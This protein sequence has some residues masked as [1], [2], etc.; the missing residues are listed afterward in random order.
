[1]NKYL[2]FFFGPMRILY[3][4]YYRNYERL[5]FSSKGSQSAAPLATL[6]SYLWVAGWLTGAVRCG[7]D[8]VS[9]IW[10]ID[11]IFEELTYFL[12]VILWILVSYSYL[13]RRHSDIIEEFRY[14]PTPD[15]LDFMML[16]IF[17]CIPSLVISVVLSK[18]HFLWSTGIVFSIYFL[19]YHFYFSELL[20]RSQKGT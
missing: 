16:F 8:F 3:S 6:T 10:T 17:F 14:L 15:V 2:V 19:F 1:V 13:K 5:G 4:F 20:K 7:F 18:S 9:S 11:I 12:L